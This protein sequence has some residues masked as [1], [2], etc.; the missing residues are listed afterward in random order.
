MR[1]ENLSPEEQEII[2]NNPKTAKEMVNW[3]KA[4]YGVKV[5]M[6]ALVL[7]KYHLRKLIGSGGFGSVYTVKENSKIVVKIE[8]AKRDEKMFNKEVEIQN[9]AA[10]GG[11]CCPIYEHNIELLDRELYQEET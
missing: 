2:K 4:M 1:S 3:K 9:K 8:H 11:Y 7:K 5:S 10:D 6:S